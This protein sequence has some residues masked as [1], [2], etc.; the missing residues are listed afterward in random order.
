MDNHR[1][2]LRGMVGLQSFQKPGPVHVGQSQV[3]KNCGRF[4][5]ARKAQTFFAVG[6]FQGTKRR[7]RKE[8]PRERE[9]LPSISRTALHCGASRSVG[10]APWRAS[11]KRERNVLHSFLSSSSGSS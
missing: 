8:R 1:D 7:F 9:R 10:S 11:V 6:S 3:E 2:I 5:L 4:P